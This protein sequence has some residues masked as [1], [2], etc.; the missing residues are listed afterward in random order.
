MAVVYLD[1]QCHLLAD[2]RY[3]SLLRLCLD[4][5]MPARTLDR[6]TYVPTIESV[7]SSDFPR[8]YTL[9]HS[10]GGSGFPR[11]PRKNRAQ[12]TCT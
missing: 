5:K 3:D 1:M 7:A 11:R 6:R 12:R 8:R 10:S 2:T 9:A 4:I